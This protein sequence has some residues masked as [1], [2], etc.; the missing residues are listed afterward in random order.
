MYQ[1]SCLRYQNLCYNGVPSVH[2]SYFSINGIYGPLW[3]FVKSFPEF[4]VLFAAFSYTTKHVINL[5]LLYQKFEYRWFKYYNFS[6]DKANLKACVCFLKNFIFHQLI[7]LQKLCKTFF[8]LS[9][10]LFLFKIF[11]FLYFHVPLFFSLSA[12]ALELDPR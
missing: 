1:F 6:W 11:E 9:K 5:L 10:K 12:N 2:G 8:I 4:I 3:S 7:V